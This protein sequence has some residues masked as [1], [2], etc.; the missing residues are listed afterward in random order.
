MDADLHLRACSSD[1]AVWCRSQTVGRSC[2]V[3]L[4]SE[5]TCLS[6]TNM[7][8]LVRGPLRS[9]L[10]ADPGLQANVFSSMFGPSMATRGHNLD[11]L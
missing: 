9:S 8:L 4:A 1:E 6:G 10:W 7:G 5:G 3:A 2:R 11:L